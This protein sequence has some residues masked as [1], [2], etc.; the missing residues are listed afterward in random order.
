MSG[1]EVQCPE[2]DEPC[3]LSYEENHYEEFCG[4]WYEKGANCD[5]CGVRLKAGYGRSTIFRC[6]E[7]AV[8]EDAPRFLKDFP[9]YVKLGDTALRWERGE[10]HRAAGLWSIS[11]RLVDGKLIVTDCDDSMKHALG[12]ELNVC[13]KAEWLESNKGYV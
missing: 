11:A 10:Y 6:Q 8:V 5:A 12:M 4:E 7:L 2:C 3:G 13:T 1:N 9:K